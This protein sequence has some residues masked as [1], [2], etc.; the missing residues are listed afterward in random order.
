VVGT[1]DFNGDGTDDIL[2]QNSAN[3]YLADWSIQNGAISGF[4]AL[5]TVLPGTTVSDTGYYHGLGAGGSGTSDILLNSGGTLIDYGVTHSVVTSSQ[6][7]GSV[8]GWT[9]V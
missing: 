2:L 7:L 8:P 6:V 5:G 4:S 3:N 9:A 1:G